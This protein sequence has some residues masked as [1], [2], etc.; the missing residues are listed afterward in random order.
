MSSTLSDSALAA[1]LGAWDLAEPI[2]VTPIP[3]GFTSNVWYV[4]TPEQRLVAKYAYDAQAAFE[5]GLRAAEVL[6]RAGMLC[7][8]PIRTR[9]GALSLLVEGPHGQSE[10]LAVLRFVP[11]MA[12]DWAGDMA[13]G[14]IGDFMG[15]VHSIWHGAVD[16]EPPDDRIFG[17]IAEAAPEVAAQPG[18][19]ELLQQ[20]VANVRAFEATTPVTYGV[21]IGD[22]IELLH[23][24]T[25]A[26]LGLIDTGAVGWGP[27][28]FDVA[29]MQDQFPA[30]EPREHFLSAY[31]AAAPV[32][33]GELA[34]LQHYAALHWAQIAKFFAWRVAHDVRLG[35]ADPD[36]NARSLAEIRAA[37]E[38]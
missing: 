35:D 2:A 5:T 33:P 34:G 36:G 37:L 28:L 19:P 15:R 9:A 23:D 3:G 27:L 31:L 30:G 11:G 26:Q 20:V 18:L 25:T 24:T 12:L 38:A 14:R 1:A 10:P 17:Y 32:Q 6:A 16:L 7:S 4:D 8:A 21:I 13:P 22:Y 29:I